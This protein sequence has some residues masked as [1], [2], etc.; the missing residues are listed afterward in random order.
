MIENKPEVKLWKSTDLS[1][2]SK[3]K[4][5]V[6]SGWKMGSLCYRPP[7]SQLHTELHSHRSWLDACGPL[8]APRCFVL[9]LQRTSESLSCTESFSCFISLFTDLL[10]VKKSSPLCTTLCR[11]ACPPGFSEPESGWR[12]D[13]TW[14]CH[15]RNRPCVGPALLS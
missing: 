7:F 5:N 14:V 6:A 1:R 4:P 13:P 3:N 15:H 9:Q 12:T 10:E 2:V 8:W 11:L